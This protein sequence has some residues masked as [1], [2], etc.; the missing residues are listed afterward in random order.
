MPDPRYEVPEEVRGSY[1]RFLEDKDHKSLAD[2]LALLRVLLEQAVKNR[3][4]T[5][6]TV[7][8]F[9]EIRET[10]TTMDRIEKERQYLVD[11]KVV[12]VLIQRL[13]LSVKSEVSD[14]RTLEAVSRRMAELPLPG[15][16]QVLAAAGEPGTPARVQKQPVRVLQGSGV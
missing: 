3:E 6:D 10:I 5:K 11:V 9:K 12:Q 15:G 16:V 7:S 4:P 8:L 2:E 13:G 14:V 1:T